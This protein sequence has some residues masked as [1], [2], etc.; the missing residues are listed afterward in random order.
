MKSARLAKQLGYVNSGLWIL[1]PSGKITPVYNDKIG[2][3]KFSFRHNSEIHTVKV[4][5]FESLFREKAPNLVTSEAK[6]KH[7]EKI[8]K[9]YLKNRSYAMTMARFGISKG[10]LFLILQRLKMPK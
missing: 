6:K 4:S 1:S 2:I 5:Q 3:L 7:H 8:V 9:F 10:G